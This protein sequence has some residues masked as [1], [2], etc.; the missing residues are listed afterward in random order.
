[1]NHFELKDGEVVCEQVPLRRI[2]EAVGTPVYVYSTATLERHFT[3]FRD[4][5]TAHPELGAPLIAYALKANANIAVVRTLARLGAGAD[6][7]SEGEI[8]RALLAGV[9]GERIV[10][11]GVG[12]RAAELAFALEVGVAEINVESEPELDLLARIAADKGVRA[13]VAIRVNPEV[14]AG[15]HD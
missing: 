14:G 13:A 9:P 1:V 8:R 2:A 7:V 11:S 4:A 5:F 15:G 12:K 10:F 3:V 6:T